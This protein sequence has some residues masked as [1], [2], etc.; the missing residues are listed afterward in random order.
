MSCETRYNS[1]RI[2]YIKV[3]SWL[4]S[5]FQTFQRRLDD[6]VDFNRTWND[7]LMGFGIPDGNFWLGK[8]LKRTESH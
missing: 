5:L 2:A 3:V 4:T 7:Y 1:M 8:C 6:S